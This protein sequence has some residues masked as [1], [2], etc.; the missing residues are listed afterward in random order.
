[1]LWY[2]N[3]F[4]NLPLNMNDRK[5]AKYETDMEFINTFNRLMNLALDTLKWEGLPETCNAD[6]LNFRCCCMVKLFL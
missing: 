3:I 2:Q 4:G 5:L 1:M 6:S